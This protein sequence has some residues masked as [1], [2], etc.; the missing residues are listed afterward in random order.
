MQAD[1]GA[2]LRPQNLADMRA[3]LNL[4]GF[5]TDFLPLCGGQPFG[6]WVHS[7]RCSPHV[8]PHPN[9]R[10]TAKI[11]P[12]AR[13]CNK[14]QGAA[15]GYDMQQVRMNIPLRRG[16]LF[17]GIQKRDSCVQ[18]GG[19][20][21]GGADGGRQQQAAAV[22]FLS[23]DGCVAATVRGGRP[24]QSRRG[25]CG[26]SSLW[27]GAVLT[28]VPSHF[29][30]SSIPRTMGSFHCRSICGSVTRRCDEE[31]WRAGF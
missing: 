2:G 4:S 28:L 24:L 21:G 12:L 18:V 1:I 6:G 17:T 27:P 16:A 7:H 11:T 13:L 9:K 31:L 15:N 26:P 23:H 14:Q 22:G 8:Q 30:L 20:V 19:C 25:R 10:P 29:C 5:L 3:F